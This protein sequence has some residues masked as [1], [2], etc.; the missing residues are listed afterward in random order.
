MATERPLPLHYD[1]ARPAGLSAWLTRLAVMFSAYPL[2]MACMMYAT[3]LAAWG[4]LG[5]RPRPSLDDPK[6]IAP[7]VD[8]LYNAALVLMTG[9]PVALLL[10]AVFAT[11]DLCARVARA[12][13]VKPVHVAAGVAVIG[14]WVGTIALLGWDPGLVGY[15]FMD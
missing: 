12:R 9:A 7:L 1:R 5:H 14:S 6:S 13:R 4:L 11:A 3:W 8:V 2:L 15:W 10:S